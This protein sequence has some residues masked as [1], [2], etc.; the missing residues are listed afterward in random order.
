MAAPEHGLPSGV[1]LVT[2]A[3]GSR[4]RLDLNGMTATRY[5]DYVED[6]EL[7]NDAAECRLLGL[8]PPKIGEP[9]VMSL[10]IRDDGVPTIRTTNWITL[11]EQVG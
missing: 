1:L 7:R 2:T 5:P 8:T 6:N 11:I 3:S 10:A 9:L 4:Y